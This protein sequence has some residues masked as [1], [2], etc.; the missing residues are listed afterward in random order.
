MTLQQLNDVATDLNSLQIS[1]EKTS[2]HIFGAHLSSPQPRHANILLDTKLFMRPL[3]GCGDHPAKISIKC[4]FGLLLKDR[5]STREMLRRRNMEL[6]DY[7]CVCCLQMVEESL[8]HLFI[9]CPFAHACWASI[10]LMVGQDDPFTTLEQLKNQLGVPFFVEVIV[11]M[12][13][14]I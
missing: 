7:N 2:G 4:Y 8:T 12:C 10:G 13:W 5:L 14:C 1:S 9:H 3:S 6:P 11:L